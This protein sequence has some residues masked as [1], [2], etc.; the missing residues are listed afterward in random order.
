M[1][2]SKEWIGLLGNYSADLF[3]TKMCGAVVKNSII[4]LRYYFFEL[5]Y[6]IMLSTPKH[7]AMNIGLLEWQNTKLICRPMV[8]YLSVWSNV[9][10]ES[11]GVNV[12]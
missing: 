11:W 5:E 6:L 7:G 12:I 1:W 3:K 10:A 4:S 2:Q 8:K 9:I